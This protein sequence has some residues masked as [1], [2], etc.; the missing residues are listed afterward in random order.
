[1]TSWCSADA[2]GGVGNVTA[3]YVY[4]VMGTADALTGTSRL[5]GYVDLTG[6]G[7]AAA[8]GAVFSFNPSDSG[9]FEAVRPVAE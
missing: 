3:R 7:N 6:D 5:L 4:Y 2:V 8:V 9:L 1:M